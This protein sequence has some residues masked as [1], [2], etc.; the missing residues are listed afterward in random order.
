MLFRTTFMLKS[1]KKE[2]HFD[3][4]HNLL[5]FF[6]KCT[7]TL[8]SINLGYPSFNFFF[9]ISTI[10]YNFLLNPV[11]I[12]KIPIFILEKEKRKKL[13]GFKCWLEFNGI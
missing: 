3:L 8:K 12:S 11:K 2:L 6:K 10:C 7:Q 5:S 1:K 13:I 4:A 9:S